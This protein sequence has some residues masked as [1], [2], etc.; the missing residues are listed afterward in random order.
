MAT[1]SRL[2]RRLRTLF[3]RKRFRSELDEEMAFHREQAE[4]ELVAAGMT[5]DEARYAAMRRFGNETRM[6]ERTHETV[7]FGIEHLWQDCRYAARQIV[8]S[9]GF[10]IAVVGTLTLGIGATTAI[11]TLVYGALMRSLPYPQADRIV[12]INDVRLQGQSTGGLVSVPRF[13]DVQGRTTS[14]ESMGF[15]FFE[16]ATLI[17][18]Q[19]LPISIRRAGTNAGFWKVYRAHPLLGR[20][21][22]ERDDQPNAPQVAVLSYTAWRQIFGGDP[23]VIG[24]QVTIEEKSTTIVGVMPRDFNVPNGIDLWCPAQ[25]NTGDWKWRGEGTRFI[26]V[27]ARLNPGASLASAQSDLQR[28][29]E[30]LRHEHPDTDG[31]WQFGSRSLRDDLYGEL[32]PALVVLLIASGFLLLIACIN[33]SNLFLT[34]ATARQR[35][36]ALRRAL[37]ASQRRIQMQ[38]LTASSLLSL[39]GG[40]AGLALTYVLIRGIATRLPGRLGTPGTVE[41]NWPAVWLAFALAVGAGV[42]FGFAP[43]LR[44]RRGEL[45]SSLKSG[46]ARI[47]GAAGGAVRSAFIAIQVCLSLVLLVG[48]SLLSE[49]LWNLIKSPLGF[50]PDHLL[51]FEVSLPWSSNQAVIRNFFFSTQQKI[52]ALP[53]VSAVGQIDALPTVDW[54]LRSNFDADWLPRVANHPRIGAEDRHIA[55]DYL[56]AMGTTLLSGRAFTLADQSAKPIPVIVNQ[57]LARQYLPGGDPVGKHLFVGNEAFPIVGVI[58][59]V[60]GTA[61]SIAKPPGPEVYWPADADEGVIQRY[62]IVRSQTPPEQL[63]KSIQQQVH[64]V[65]PRQAI[66][67][68]ATMDDLLSQSVAQPRLNMALIAA[69]AL[70]ALLLACV[71]IYGVVAWSVAQRVQEIGVRMALGAT[72]PQILRLIVSRAA[73]ATIVGLA[74]G[75]CLALLLTRL[76][77]SQ[78][79]GVSPDSPSIYAASILLLLVPALLAALR[80]ALRAASVNPVEALRAE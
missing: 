22:D 44:N 40:L 68:V 10:A 48:A 3:L 72:R 28:I 32:R 69:F 17:A 38:F 18:G 6:R 12:R 64:E 79:Y 27:F 7:E 66:S 35:E 47:A 60:R 43:A 78:L 80:P 76:L 19:Q 70:I 13:Y 65:D 24:G 57:Q 14:F 55:G 1:L 71:G 59:D 52:E 11:F 45:N 41:M 23:G 29:G 49:S 42:A 58:A 46:E 20:T 53:G 30:Q 5:R 73:S 31:L 77:R 54:H 26:N 4:R 56:A 67:G 39:A 63:I 75:T 34:R 33:V 9:P 36:V 15:F 50:A 51:T 37:G 16:R 61:G 21:F 25:F 62:F 74:A 8:R 2:A